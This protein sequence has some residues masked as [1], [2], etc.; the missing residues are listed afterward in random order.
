MHRDG[1]GQTVSV[2]CAWKWR[3]RGSVRLVSS[4]DGQQKAHELRRM[5]AETDASMTARSTHED[6]DADA[7][8]GGDA[9]GE[10][11]LHGTLQIIDGGQ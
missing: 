6:V 7:N 10:V 11:L 4:T 1:V 3:A 5:K 8:L 2:G 9:I